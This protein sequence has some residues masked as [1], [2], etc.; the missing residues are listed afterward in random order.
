MTAGQASRT[1]LHCPAS[2]EGRRS[3]A[4]V[5]SESCKKRVKRRR[6]RGL[7][8]DFL[9][10][11]GRRGVP[12]DY[13]VPAEEL[14]ATAFNTGYLRGQWAGFKVDMGSAKGN[15]D[16]MISWLEDVKRAE[17]TGGEIG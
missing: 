15:I 11:G 6:K 4:L 9:P 1:C 16:A 2:L 3:D 10:E 14:I 17:E 12:L 8:P 5:C 13:R 7:P